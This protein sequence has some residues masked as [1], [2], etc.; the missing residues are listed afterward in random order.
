MKSKLKGE[1]AQ[2]QTTDGRI[3][4]ASSAGSRWGVGNWQY[5]ALLSTCIN[6]R[7]TE[8]VFK[9]GLYTCFNDEEELALTTVDLNNHPTSK[10]VPYKNVFFFLSFW[11]KS[12]TF[13]PYER[14]NT[15]DAQSTCTKHT[16]H[17]TQLRKHYSTPSIT[18]AWL[19]LLVHILKFT[20]P[21]CLDDTKCRY[22]CIPSV[23]PYKV[24]HQIL[25]SSMK[26]FSRKALISLKIRSRKFV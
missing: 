13:M 6:S 10:T 22:Y 17:K 23:Q 25:Q 3:L 2:K 7:H 12:Y 18:S 20:P 4:R 8:S 1:R 24:N 19:K 9:V 11:G 5:P 14:F 15:N 26:T 21:C 16:R